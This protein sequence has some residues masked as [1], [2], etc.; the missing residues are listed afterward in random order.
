ME[1]HGGSMVRVEGI[2][3]RG[4]VRIMGVLGLGKVEGAG[5]GRRK[6]KDD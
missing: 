2:Q 6:N 4:R 5:K 3:E 1:G